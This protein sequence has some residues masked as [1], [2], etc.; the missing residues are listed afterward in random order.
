M[1][2]PD[3]PASAQEDMVMIASLKRMARE[4]VPM[5]TL[6]R[7]AAPL[8][9]AQLAE[10]LPE[11]DRICAEAEAAVAH[12]HYTQAVSGESVP[13]TL[14]WV[15]ARIYETPEVENVAVD[16]PGAL[17][18]LRELLDAFASHRAASD[19]ASTDVAEASSSRATG[20]DRR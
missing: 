10:A 15:K 8:P 9:P 7:L 20:A 14:A 3:P 17:A 18:S 11:L 16:D 4:G 1:Q 6:T 13:A 5:R 19:G 12:T 2:A